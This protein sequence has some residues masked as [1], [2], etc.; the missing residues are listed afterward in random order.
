MLEGIFFML[1]FCVLSNLRFIWCVYG[2]SRVQKASC[3][4]NES[5]NFEESLIDGRPVE[6][7]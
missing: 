3:A 2:M 7:K 6:I 5:V 1:F 4:K